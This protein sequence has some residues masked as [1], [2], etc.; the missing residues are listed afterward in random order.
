[1]LS[2][3]R[4]YNILLSDQNIYWRLCKK[5][6][7]IPKPLSNRPIPI[8]GFWHPGKMLVEC[9]WR[10]YLSY[11]LSS[12]FHFLFP[13][14]CILYK[15][16]LSHSLEFLMTLFISYQKSNIVLPIL[17]ANSPYYSIVEN[18]R[19]LYTY[20]LPLVFEYF[21]LIKR[22][23]WLELLYLYIHMIQAFIV[24]DCPTYSKCCILFYCQLNYWEKYH[25]DLY[26]II[27]SSSSMF[28]EEVG[29]ISLSRLCR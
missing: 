27:S 5:Y 25:P 16:R 10:K 4:Y 2:K 17:D 18:I 6:Y 22:N 12:A 13:K 1:M 26:K 11:F 15:P 29:E 20:F 24:L 28:N 8:L 21:T 7:N 23:S 9:I 3:T 19:L 14:S